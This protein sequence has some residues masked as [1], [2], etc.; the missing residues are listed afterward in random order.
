MAKKQI[1]YV[2]ASMDELK[3]HLK[4]QK[5]QEALL[6]LAL[7]LREQPQLEDMLTRIV[8]CVAEL[9]ATERAVRLEQA[10]NVD[11]EEAKLQTEVL[12]TRIAKLRERVI[13][14]T[15]DDPNAVRMRQMY[16]RNLR[17]AEAQLE[18][19]GLSKKLLKFKQHFDTIQDE[20]TQLVNEWKTNEA[21][22]AFDLEDH[23][24]G[25]GR[26]VGDA[27]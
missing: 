11:E 16:E 13:K 2:T 20:L 5:A 7:S 4:K 27:E 25:V 23:I 26:Y 10:T 9:K 22:K 3:A 18:L 8:T 21:Y 14:F 12:N 19:V 6:E 17:E 15:G 1:E 24:P